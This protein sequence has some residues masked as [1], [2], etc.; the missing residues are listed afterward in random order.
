M[1]IKCHFKSNVA[2]KL[3][4]RAHPLYNSVSP[5][6]KRNERNVKKFINIALSVPLCSLSVK[7]LRSWELSCNSLVLFCRHIVVCKLKMCAALDTFLKAN[8]KH[9]F[10]L[11][12]KWNAH[13]ITTC[14]SRTLLKCNDIITDAFLREIESSWDEMKKL[15]FGI[16][17]SFN[18]F[19]RKTLHLNEI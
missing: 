2:I 15:W 18:F 5:L 10:Y 7:N 3:I 14:L 6:T 16:Q 17:I 8:E 1:K 9:H 19:P 11:D 12:I 13:A 4:E